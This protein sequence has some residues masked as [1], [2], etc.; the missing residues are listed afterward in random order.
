MYLL[1]EKTMP[2]VAF[3]KLGIEFETLRR[4]A[5]TI[6]GINIYWYAIFIMIALVGGLFLALHQAKITGQNP[7]DYNDFFIYGVILAV[8]GA[9]LYY[10]AF[11]W[12]A[13]KNDLLRIF[14]FRE[15]GL[16]I[17]GAIIGGIIALILFCK[18]KKKSFFLMADTIVASLPFG[19]AIGRLGNFV[20]KEAFGG[21]TDSL[22]AMSIRADKAAYIPESV[23]KHM[24]VING[25]SYISVQP[26]FLY[27]ATWSLM[28]VVVLLVYRKHKKFDGEVFFLY[29][30][31]YG[32]GRAIIEGF[33]T[34]QLIIA[35]TGIP[36]S[37]L[38]GV[39]FAIVSIIL[40][41]LFRKRQKQVQYEVGISEEE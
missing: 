37:Q 18:Y 41:V 19:Q 21:Y 35:N 5:F 13:Y 38:L 20:N 33:R 36:V 6:F 2:D 17:Y 15:G 16:A 28:T 40:I 27:E 30:L 12:D 26:T 31:L 9:R 23:A 24:S 1:L 4:E 34:D 10:V 8:I 7:D 14:A 32:V 22:F 39:V 25:T 11:E 29:M 3:F